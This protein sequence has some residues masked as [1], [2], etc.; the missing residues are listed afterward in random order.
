MCWTDTHTL[1]LCLSVSLSHSLSLTLSLL[2][3]CN[4][5]GRCWDSWDVA[6]ITGTTWYSPIALPQKKNPT[7]AA[8]ASVRPSIL[9]YV[10]VDWD[11]CQRHCILERARAYL[12][13][14]SL[15][16]DSCLSLDCAKKTF[17]L[18]T[19]VFWE[20]RKPQK[21]QSCVNVVLP[22]VNRQKAEPSAGFSEIVTRCYC[23]SCIFFFFF[24]TK[25]IHM[26][27]EHRELPAGQRRA[28]VVVL[29]GVEALSD[30][31]LESA[32][33]RKGKSEQEKKQ[34]HPLTPAHSPTPW[35]TLTHTDSSWAF[36][37]KQLSPEKSCPMSI[38]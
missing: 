28:A 29:I 27:C 12:L 9:I 11:I 17:G 6:Q 8:T 31:F 38:L 32:K 22:L 25:L 33:E 2:C 24:C 37:R 26:D 15:C 4:R 14:M 30:L 16:S 36:I 21:E 23:C 34:H 18:C 1:L 10:I 5:V 7:S 13:K 20:G 19:K 35:Q 3:M